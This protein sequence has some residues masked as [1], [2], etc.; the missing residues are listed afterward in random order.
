MTLFLII[1]FSLLGS[2]GCV[3]V[4]TLLFRTEGAF[5]AYLKNLVLSYAT[6][7]LLGAAFLG[8][9]PHALDALPASRALAT[10]LAGL[11]GFFVLE[12][13]LVWRHCHEEG[14]PIH[15]QAGPLILV[16]DGVHNFIDGIAIA[17][18]FQQSWALGSATALAVIAHEIPQ[19]VGDIM[20]LLHQGWSRRRAVGS[21]VLS[22]L[23]TVPGALL[24]YWVGRQVAGIAPYALAVS[25]ASFIYIALADLTPDHRA[26][27]QL[28]TTLL[29]LAG[30]AAGIG[31]IAL[32]RVT[33][34]A[35]S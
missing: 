24:A 28:R 22:S 15:A 12:K 17:L 11:V 13:L 8:M 16:G 18:A 6:G 32:V 5:S 3:L 14:C 31:T 29:Q 1:F 20:I 7:T 26:Q 23:M 34:H 33:G 35:L 19:E 27:P 10:V 21:N 9:I 4:A 2:V 25:A 30:I